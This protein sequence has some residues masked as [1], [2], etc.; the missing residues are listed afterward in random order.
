MGSM[1]TNILGRR[2]LYFINIKEMDVHTDHNHTE[3]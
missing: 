3:Q 2:D 1:L